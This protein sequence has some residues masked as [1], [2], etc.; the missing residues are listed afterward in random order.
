MPKLYQVLA[1]KFQARV[2]CE[3]SGN[4]DWFDRHEDAIR[5]LFDQ[6]P[7]GSGIDSAYEIDWTTSNG[8]KIVFSFSFHHMNENGY[9]DGWTDHTVTVTG[10][11]QFGFN[12]KISGRNRNDIKDYLYDVFNEAFNREVEAE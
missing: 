2:N 8:E 5:K 1:Q 11:L 3:K 7:H 12:L 4:M 6:L 10:S 9:Y